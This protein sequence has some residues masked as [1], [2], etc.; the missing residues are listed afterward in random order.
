MGHNPSHFRLVDS[1]LSMFIIREKYLNYGIFGVIQNSMYNYIYD[2]SE[3]VESPSTV[4]TYIGA[5]KTIGKIA[6]PQ[7]IHYSHRGNHFQ[8]YSLYE[9]ASIIDVI[10]S[11]KRITKMKPT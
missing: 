11:K 2:F 6:F 1:R 4:P 8:N 10:L 9:F 7:Y 5:T 3:E